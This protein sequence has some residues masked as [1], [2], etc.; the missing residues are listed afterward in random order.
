MAKRAEINY[1]DI[2]ITAADYS[3]QTAVKVKELMNNYKNVHAKAEA[4]HDLEHEADVECHRLYD[5]LN[6]AFITPIDREDIYDLIKS[7]DDITDLLEDVS[8][9]LDMFN[10]T[11][12]RPEALT[13]GELMETTASQMLALM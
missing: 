12:V 4:I 5:A 10:I 7:I 3:H 13:M 6:V 11:S 1:F 2:L 9:R 8:N